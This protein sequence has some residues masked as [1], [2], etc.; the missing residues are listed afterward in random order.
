MTEQ[1]LVDANVLK[2][3]IYQSLI[4]NPHDENRI[5]LNHIHEHQNFLNI[6]ARQ[7]V[8]NARPI[9]HG[10]I[11]ETIEDGKMKRIFSCCGKDFTTLTTWCIPN[12]CPNCGADMREEKD[13]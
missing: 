10:K 13:L 2:E 4:N 3:E 12:F 11:I 5:Y 8:I 6:L 1:Q 9:V 7:P